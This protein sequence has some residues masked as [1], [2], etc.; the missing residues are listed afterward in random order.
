MIYVQRPGRHQ[1]SSRSEALNVLSG[2]NKRLDHLGVDEVAVE[3]VELAQPEVVASEVSVRSSVRVAP[4]VAEVLHQHKRL[5]ELP[6]SEQL[7]S[8]KLNAAPALGV[9]ATSGQ[10]STER[11]E[12]RVHSVVNASCPRIERVKRV[13]IQLIDELRRRQRCRVC[14]GGQE[15]RALYEVEEEILLVRSPDSGRLPAGQR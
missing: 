11:R 15:G 10:A 3:L 4:Q 2:S 13:A 14:A 5:V 9:S 1:S 6:L 12:H 7:H 8:P